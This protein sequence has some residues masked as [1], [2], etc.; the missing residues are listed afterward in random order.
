VAE[1]C[2][3]GGAGAGVNALVRL[4]SAGAG[5][6]WPVS[7]APALSPP[8]TDWPPTPPTQPAADAGLSVLGLLQLPVYIWT[9]LACCKC[10]TGARRRHQHC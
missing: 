4:H 9:V 6:G 3:A 1:T 2:R 5:A 10:M 8:P 7:P